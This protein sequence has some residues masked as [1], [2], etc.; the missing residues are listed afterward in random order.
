MGNSRREKESVLVSK[1]VPLNAQ[2]PKG[3]YIERGIIY[4][5]NGKGTPTSIGYI[6]GD[7][8]YEF[9]PGTKPKPFSH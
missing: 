2:I 9:V 1:T 3:S 6:E 7:T 4:K 5:L 8:A